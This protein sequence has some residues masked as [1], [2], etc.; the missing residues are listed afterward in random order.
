MSR[1][2]IGVVVV[3]F[4]TLLVSSGV[5]M[6][7]GVFLAPLTGEFGGSRAAVSLAAT[8]NLIVFGA[9]QPFFGRMI[10]V[11]GPRRVVVVGLALMSLGA[12]ATSQATALWH[13]YLSY[14][15]LGGMGFTGAGILAIAVLVLRWFRQSRG[16]AL[17]MIATGSSLGQ[18]IFYQGASWLI[19]TMGWRVTCGVFGLL[20]AALVPV[21]LWLVRDDP[22]GETSADRAAPARREAGT[23][24]LSG[25]VTGAP[26]LLLAGA[27]LACGFTDFMITTHLAVLAVDRGLGSTT[28]ARA[29]SVLAVANIAGLL[30]AGRLAD[31]AGNRLTLVV[32]YLVRALA[33][34]LLWFVGSTAGLY[35][36]A[37]VFGLTFFTTA[38]LTSALVN[39]LFGLALTG[40]VF[41]AVSAIHHLAG[42]AG[43]YLAGEAFDLTGSYLPV[44]VLGAAMVYGG[45]VLTWRIDVRESRRAPR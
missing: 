39:E 21:C 15:V 20:L 34:T 26:F 32:V 13:L 31:H 3:A 40:R 45:T 1:D 23:P 7:F 16:T 25:V 24:G 18:A 4:V 43:A 42:A 30:V 5:N 35:A 36:F 37:F 8:T 28:G 12:L 11:F 9:A 29:L 38:P 44:F 19:A 6:S 14:G 17:T 33:L 2:R 41:G 27:Y 10:D 22:P